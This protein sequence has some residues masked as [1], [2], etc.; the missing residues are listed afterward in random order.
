M[1]YSD[2]SII[3]ICY[4]NIFEKKKE[5]VFSIH[6]LYFC[7]FLYFLYFCIFYTW[8]IMIIQSYIYVI[9]ISFKKKELVFSIHGVQ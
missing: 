6:V 8:N 3:Y 7:I 2:N 1:E 5:L 4:K 9:K